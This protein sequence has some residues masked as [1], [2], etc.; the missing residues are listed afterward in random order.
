MGEAAFGYILRCAL[1]PFAYLILHPHCDN[2]F[3]C[4]LLSGWHEA[5]YRAHAI[6]SQQTQQQQKF[7]METQGSGQLDMHA[8]MSLELKMAAKTLILQR[9]ARLQ[10]LLERESKMYES[11]LNAM[12][13]TVARDTD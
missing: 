4:A 12:G 6:P 10:S 8:E 3:R 5:Q 11:E 7:K 9:R 1:K 13:L 2:I